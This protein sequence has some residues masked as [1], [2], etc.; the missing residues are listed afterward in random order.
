[1]IYTYSVDSRCQDDIFVILQI[2]LLID[3]TL[4]LC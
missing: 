3:S 2:N 1:M 4:S